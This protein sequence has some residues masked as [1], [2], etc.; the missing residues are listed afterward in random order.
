M[1]LGGRG[2]AVTS[3]RKSFSVTLHNSGVESS[4]RTRPTQMSFCMMTSMPRSSMMVCFM[5]ATVAVTSVSTQNT[6]QSRTPRTCRRMA[7]GAQPALYCDRSCLPCPRAVWATWPVLLQRR[8]RAWQARTLR[9][10]ASTH[11]HKCTTGEDDRLLGAHVAANNRAAT[12]HA[13]ARIGRS[14]G[15]AARSATPG[16]P[17]TERAPPSSMLPCNLKLGIPTMLFIFA[18]RTSSLP[19]YVRAETKR[20]LVGR[21]DAMHRDV[22]LPCGE[23]VAD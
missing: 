13:A 8:A 23:P 6:A 18:Q 14:V 7:R 4:A 10:R 5:L 9:T 17:L 15:A 3:T 2:F 11:T 16:R 21:E 20:R 22:L 1:R 12:A 19:M